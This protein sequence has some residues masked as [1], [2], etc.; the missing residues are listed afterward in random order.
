VKD[1]A[2]AERC[3]RLRLVLSDVDGVMTDG[4]LLFLPDGREA[5]AFHIRDGPAFARASSPAAPPRP[6]RGGRRSSLWTWYGRAC[7]TKRPRW[8]R[9]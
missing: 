8:V 5:K 2:L 9:S 1:A 6:W 3:R 7:P 4:T